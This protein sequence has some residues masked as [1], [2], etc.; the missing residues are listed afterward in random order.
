MGRR[1]PHQSPSEKMPTLVFLTVS[2]VAGTDTN[3]NF[4]D[5]SI[6]YYERILKNAFSYVMIDNIGN[7]T[8]R[9]TYNRP[10]LDLTTYID[11]AK[12]LKAGDALYVEEDVQNI[13]IH[14]IEDS[15]VEMVLKSDKDV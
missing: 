10:Y 8:I 4:I 6:R 1:I 3:F 9:V 11:G 14:F 12:T 5:G 7:G 2:E 15:I 13:K